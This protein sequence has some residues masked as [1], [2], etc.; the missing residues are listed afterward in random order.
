[1]SELSGR[2]VNYGYDSIYWLTNETIASDPNGV[3]G[4]VSYVYDAVGNLAT[5]TYPNAVAHS[6]TYDTRNRLTTLGVAKGATAI[7]SYGYALDAAG[8][9]LSVSELSG[10]TVNYGYDTIYRLTNETI[11]SDPNGVNGAI[12][13][14][15]DAVGNRKQMTST[16]PGLPAGLWNYDAND[17]FTAG[18]TY[19]NDGNTVSSGGIADVYDFENHLVQQGGIG[20]VYDG[21]GNRVSKTVAGATTQYLV[22]TQNPTGYAQVMDE[23]QS[24]AVARTYTWGLELISELFPAGSPL[25]T[26]H[27]P[28]Y[29]VF[30]GHGSVRALTNSGGAATDTYDYDAFGNLIHSTGSTPN[31]YLFAGEQFD[32]DLNLYYNRA[33]YLNTSTGRFWSMDAYEGF[34]QEPLS[35]HKYLYA[36]GDPL[37]RTDR[38]G[39]EI[40][41][42]LAGFAVSETLDAMPTLLFPA[43]PRDGKLEILF[44][45][46]N[47]SGLEFPFGGDL[48]G[49]FEQKDT[50]WFWNVEMRATLP[51]GTDASQY[52][53]KQTR[54]TQASGV[55]QMAARLGPFRFRL[56]VRPDDPESNN[57][58][59]V[60][61]ILYAIDQPGPNLVVDLE[62]G[63]FGFVDSIT[64]EQHFVTWVQKFADLRGTKLFAKKWH[65]KIVARPGGRLDKSASEAKVD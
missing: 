29:Y 25:S 44:A 57:T 11:A 28:L 15:Y 3:N 22:D 55:L 51:A 35:F 36:A 6:Y 50:K 63:Q 60:K 2:T 13:Y 38:G 10:R 7:A 30:D 37:N 34:D 8:H 5:V 45:G 61:N 48:G 59:A 58:K 17:R 26:N 32:P 1:V 42:L 18:D 49:P 12:G 56:P 65:V 31:N 46:K 40:D 33:R 39:N 54:E 20:I 64:T 27:S 47:D 9:R 52:R 43:A 23:V 21:D 62:G 41:D 14:A 16:V 19:D 24:S 53:I 4:A